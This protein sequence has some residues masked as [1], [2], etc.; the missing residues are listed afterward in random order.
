MKREHRRIAGEGKEG[1][2]VLHARCLR[3][4][5]RASAA[6]LRTKRCYASVRRCGWHRQVVGGACNE[7]YV[8]PG[9]VLGDARRADVRREWRCVLE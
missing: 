6:F 8:P 3:D 4:A 9:R 7:M 1:D 5:A 2:S